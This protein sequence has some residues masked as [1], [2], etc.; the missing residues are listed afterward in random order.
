[1]TIVQADATYPEQYLQEASVIEDNDINL[2]VIPPENIE[3]PSSVEAEAVPQKLEVLKSVPKKRFFSMFRS[4]NNDDDLDLFK[5]TCLDTEKSALS[6]SEKGMLDDILKWNKKNKATFIKDKLK[7]YC[8]VRESLS[9]DPE[10]ESKY[11]KLYIWT[12][13]Y[14]LTNRK[15]QVNS[16][17]KN[18]KTLDDAVLKRQENF[19]EQHPG[20]AQLIDALNRE[21]GVGVRIQKRGG[22][23]RKRKTT[24]K[25]KRK[26]RKTKRLYRNLKR[27]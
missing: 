16:N 9:F 8:D 3:Y 25:N 23:R 18:F 5:N 6:E 27:A 12:L 19:M 22:T 4:S 2:E 26:N 11:P 13:Y 14:A 24:K 7:Y 17:I 15:S 20:S 10:L 1:M 21:L